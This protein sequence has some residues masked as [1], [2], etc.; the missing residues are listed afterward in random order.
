MRFKEFLNRIDPLKAPFDGLALGVQVG[1]RWFSSKRLLDLPFS[2]KF[3]EA[4]TEVD[5]LRLPSR[6]PACIRGD[7]EPAFHRCLLATHCTV[8]CN[9]SGPRCT[10]SASKAA[11]S[12]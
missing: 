8:P 10:V 12:S 4:N 11:R 3:E 6:N 1:L 2:L 5:T 7:C 9:A